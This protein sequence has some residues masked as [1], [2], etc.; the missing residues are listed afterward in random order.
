MINAISHADAKGVA[1]ERINNIHA[2]LMRTLT[3]GATVEER[4]TWKTKEEAARA[5]L[6]GSASNGQKAMIDFEAAGAGEDPVALATRIVTKA[7]SFQALIGIAAGLRQKARAGIT[8]A[9][10]PAVPLVEVN[11]RVDQVFNK[12]DSEVKLAIAEWQGGD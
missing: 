4:D 9:T 2:A 6:D 12:I 7:E 1:F 8:M 5:Y 11:A 3:G 10:D